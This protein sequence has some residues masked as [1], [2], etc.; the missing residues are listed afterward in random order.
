MV[1]VW[2]DL[3]HPNAIRRAKLVL[4]I[5][6]D[7]FPALHLI[8]LLLRLRV[9]GTRIGRIDVAT[10]R[11]VHTGAGGAGATHPREKH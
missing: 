7:G 5:I 2:I 3:D 11:A 4:H 10:G 6:A 8:L 1:G 9:V